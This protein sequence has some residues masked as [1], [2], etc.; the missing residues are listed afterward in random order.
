MQL[1]NKLAVTKQA[2]K[3]AVS[4]TKELEGNLA[5]VSKMRTKAATNESSINEEKQVKKSSKARSR[6]ADVDDREAHA[7]RAVPSQQVDDPP[8]VIPRQS[9]RARS[10]AA[11]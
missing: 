11:L 3:N 10:L 2:L 1:G 5:T 7:T 8:H 6:L 4:K 9:A